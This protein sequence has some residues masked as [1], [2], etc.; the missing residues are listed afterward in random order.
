MN[1]A[2]IAGLQ[3]ILLDR[4]KVQDMPKITYQM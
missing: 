2:D 1:P 4:K 3:K